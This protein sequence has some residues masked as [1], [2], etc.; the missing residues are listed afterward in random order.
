MA[1]LFKV[2]D[3]SNRYGD[4]FAIRELQD[5][6][7]FEMVAWSNTRIEA[8]CYVERVLRG[9][10]INPVIPQETDR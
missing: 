10:V 2:T 9:E 4:Y 7:S 1:R 6:M 8:E 5:D 3:E